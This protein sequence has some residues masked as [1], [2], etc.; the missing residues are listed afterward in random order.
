MEVV[1]REEERDSGRTWR[2]V[3][4]IMSEIPSPEVDEAGRGARMSGVF[5]GPG[6]DTGVMNWLKRLAPSCCSTAKAS[7]WRNAAPSGE[8]PRERH[9]PIERSSDSPMYDIEVKEE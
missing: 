1:I 6:S 4:A 3:A 5:V 9:S 2:F 7:L 8:R